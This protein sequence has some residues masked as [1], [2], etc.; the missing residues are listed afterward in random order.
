MRSVGLRAPWI[1]SSCDE[2]VKKWRIR[3]TTLLSYRRTAFAAGLVIS[4]LPIFAVALSPGVAGAVTA[5]SVSTNN[6]STC[7]TNA[8]GGVDC[9]GDNSF[10]RLGNNTTTNS[11]TP[12]A[13]VGVSDS[14]TLSGVTSV[15]VG[16]DSTCATLS[17]GGVDCWGYNRDGELGN[18]TTTQEPT[19]VAVVDVGNT[20]AFLSGVASVSVGVESACAALTT[21]GVDCWG[22]NIDGDLGLGNTTTTNSETPVAVVGVGGTGTLSGV[23]SVSVGFYSTCA[24]LSTGGVDCWGFNASGQLGNNS[25]TQ[26]PAPVEVVGVNGTGTL[27]GVTS[28]SANDNSTC[29]TLTT[30]G[31]DCWG[32]NNSGQLGNNT[33]TSSETPVEVVG[34]GG[35]ST[36]SGA[37]SVSVGYDSA[38]AMLSSG[39]VDC[40]GLNIEGELG[41]N[42]TTSPGLTPVEVVG[43]NGTDYLSGVTSV[44]VGYEATCA[45]LSS[46]GVDC[47]GLNDEGQ[48]GNNSATQE[49]TPVAVATLAS[50]LSTPAAPSISKSGT[51]VTVTY[52]ADAH[53]ASSTITLY[54]ETLTTSATFS[55]A[56]TGSHTFTGLIPGDSYRATITSVGD[57]TN[58]TTSLEGAIS[59]TETLASVLSTP[60]APSISKSGTSVTVTY[61]A[62]AHAA[63]STITLYNETL[64]TSA[65]FSDANTGSHTF[66][67]LIPGDSYR[68][69]ITSVGDGTNYTTS[70]EGAISA[71]ETL[72]SVLSTPAA[73][74]ISKSGTSVTVTYTA[75]AHAASS[76]IT[77]YNETLTTSATFSDA[78]T[79]SHTFT[80]L[81]PGDSY[82]ATITSVGDGTNYTTSL[83]GAISA[84]ETLASVPLSAPPTGPTNAPPPTSVSVPASSF[85]TPTSVTASCAAATTVSETSG[86]ASETITVPQCALPS[87]TTVSAYQVINTVPLVAQVPAGSSYVLSFAV[88]W[89]APNGTSPTATAPITMTITDPNIKAGD[90]IYELTST[91]LAAVGTATANGTVTI[92]FS[93]DPIFL[94][95]HTTP[96][97]Q[98]SLRI[99][100]LSGTLGT[101]LTLVTSGG[102][103]S[104]AVSFTVANGTATGC[105]ITGSSLTATGAGKCLVTATKAADTTYLAASS[106]ATTVRFTA[107]VIP[108]H[109][110]ATRVHRYARVGRTVTL[111]IVGTG[112]YGKPTITSNEAGTRAVVTHD[113]GKLLTVR[114]T[115]RAGSRKGKHTFTIRQANGRSCRVYYLVK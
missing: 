49:L 63:S 115:V 85:G 99:T 92:T 101:A 105:R 107:K 1:C 110:H 96:V 95:S 89:E 75:D 34:V 38:C 79:G 45:M 21:G 62:D 57:G 61:T 23:T 104:G 102:S 80:G 13:V 43:V 71:T 14:G 73:P 112:F 46:G 26:E 30:G 66:T 74:S 78:N 35:T 76:T 56:N 33:T 44:S 98:A 40:W 90:I 84:T 58:Y 67:G 72:A 18:N 69:T 48:L 7:A 15:S 77:L 29:A 87:G 17:T 100:T 24:T 93:S 70:L 10:G 111:T 47:W 53:A 68:A 27:S 50:V 42:N 82:R 20:G 103:G 8:T 12:V 81:I 65:T 11:E 5:T 31:V 25:A 37:T 113:S 109:L 22:S 32:S 41:D 60:A 51:S 19:P 106:S 3:V 52:T 54:N 2:S 4:V 114:V 97:A 39:G 88:T 36:L 64:T 91:G 94:V 86:G 59:A 55:D 108:V 16:Y 9:W 6:S 83:E 28:V